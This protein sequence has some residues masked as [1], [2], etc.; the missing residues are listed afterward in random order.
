MFI[1]QTDELQLCVKLIA[2][3]KCY[4][5]ACFYKLV[6]FMGPCDGKLRHNYMAFVILHPHLLLYVGNFGGKTLE[7]E[8]HA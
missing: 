6:I 1:K 5:D 8:L 2:V 3:F 7:N 4:N